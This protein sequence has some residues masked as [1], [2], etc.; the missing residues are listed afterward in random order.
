ME[1][2]KEGAGLSGDLPSCRMILITGG[3]G[4]VGTGLARKL[5]ERSFRVRILGLSPLESDADLRDAGVESL[6]GD[7]TRFQDLE[8]AMRGVD[9][10]YHLA[11]I[12]SSPE[13]PARY[14]AVN[15]GG[16][17][18][19]L[20]AAEQNGVRRFIFVSSVSVTYPRRNTYSASK[21]EAEEWVRRSALPWTIARPCLVSDALEYKVFEHAVLRWPVVLLPR[22]GAARKRPVTSEVLAAVLA[23]IVEDHDTVGKS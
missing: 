4:C 22:R 20:E 19:A 13:K 16:T 1:D 17:R 9:T 21:A 12:L 3:N 14:H 8:S 15:V 18:N 7:V 2:R 5:L 6:Y 11:A 23:D 10:V